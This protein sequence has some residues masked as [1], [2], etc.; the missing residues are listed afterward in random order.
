M[1]DEGTSFVTGVW[2]VERS[3]TSTMFCMMK[4][5]WDE[6]RVS[7]HTD[8]GQHADAE[9]VNDDDDDGAGGDDGGDDGGDGGGDGGGGDGGNYGDDGD[10]GDDGDGD[11]M[12]GDALARNVNDGH[13]DALPQLHDVPALIPFA[14]WARWY[15]M[16][17]P[18]EDVASTV[19]PEVTHLHLI[20]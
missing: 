11:V 10:D 14:V 18:P 12:N 5:R 7:F 15:E 19:V 16:L 13:V 20:T 9:D 1:I 2:Y 8:F 6:T 17:P 3:P 4:R